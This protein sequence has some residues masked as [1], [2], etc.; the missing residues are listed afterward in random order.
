M[1]SPALLRQILF[2]VAVVWSAESFA[3]AYPSRP[4]TLVAPFAAGSGVD[5]MAR[6]IA[7]NLSLR[8]GQ[9]IVVDNKPGAAS[10]IGSDFVARSA[11]DG[12]TLMYTANVLSVLPALYKKLPFDPVADF[13]HIS[14]VGTGGMALLVNHASFP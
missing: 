7:A 4:I 3:Q 12:Y 9:P 13:T 14:K 1:S 11:P 5:V 8:L 10:V 6:K 2:C